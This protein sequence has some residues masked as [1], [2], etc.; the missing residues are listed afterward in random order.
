M[1]MPMLILTQQRRVSLNFRMEYRIGR[2]RR[3]KKEFVA[4]IIGD[5][6][7]AG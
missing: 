5:D 7:I 4:E 1:L 3:T 2:R 6:L